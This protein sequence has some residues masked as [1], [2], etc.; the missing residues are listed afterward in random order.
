MQKGK[1]A[2]AVRWLMIS[3]LH[4]LFSKT[5]IEFPDG[6]MEFNELWEK[7]ITPKA[8]LPEGSIA[9][10]LTP[11]KAKDFSQYAQSKGVRDILLQV[12]G[13]TPLTFEAV[14]LAVL[15]GEQATATLTS[16]QDYL[17]NDDYNAL[18]AESLD[19]SPEVVEVEEDV[20]VV[21]DVQA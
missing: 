17:G 10:K 4:K 11:T 12:T 13:Q 5:S 3:G 8:D 20:E 1:D 19:G 15:A 18:L 6:T 9:Q 16:I 2:T 7:C 21:E 14:D